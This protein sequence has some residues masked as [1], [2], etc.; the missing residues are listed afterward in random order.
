MIDKDTLRRTLAR[1]TADKLKRATEENNH[2][3]FARGTKDVP[4][5]DV[6]PQERGV[7]AIS[8]DSLPKE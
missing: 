6:A 5:Q 7:E 4:L 3:P 8:S 1:K 2:L